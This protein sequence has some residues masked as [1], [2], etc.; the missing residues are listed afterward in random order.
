[1]ENNRELFDLMQEKRDLDDFLSVMAEEAAIIV[2]QRKPEPAESSSMNDV[3]LDPGVLDQ[4][5]P[6]QKMEEEPAEPLK[7][8]KLP[9]LEDN[10]FILELEKPEP[11][12][13]EADEAPDSKEKLPT[14]DDDEFVL[15]LEKPEPKSEETPEEQGE[16][17]QLSAAEDE[18]TA[19]EQK[20]E[21]ESAYELEEP[22]NRDELLPTHDDQ[23]PS[24]VTDTVSFN[25]PEETVAVS[26]Q[27][28]F[29]PTFDETEAAEEALPEAF[30]ESE[31]QSLDNIETLTRFDEI[32]SVDERQ[33]AKQLP[34]EEQYPPEKPGKEKK[35]KAE[36]KTG[37]Y[38][39]APESKSTPSGKWIGAGIGI[40]I[41]LLIILLAGYFWLYPDRAGKT[42]NFIKSYIMVFTTDQGVPAPS[43][44]GINLQQ[45]R[46]KQLY[47]TTLMKNVRVI[48]GMAENVT[49]RPVSRIKIA[50]NIYNAEGALLATTESYAG[51]VLIDEKLESL[52]EQWILSALKD[53]KTME[54][55]TSPKGQIPFMVVFAGEPAG[56]FRL[57]VNPIDLKQH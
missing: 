38:D 44:L 31:A 22:T 21:R 2:A 15:E 46:Q 11:K 8:G 53:V 27:T 20:P 35:K 52:N 24:G 18:F 50:A 30:V 12:P 42:I 23:I 14:L 34:D 3:G 45:V 9:T 39:F 36:R 57:T 41:I 48:E 5:E 16:T 28:S 26:E 10:E 33:P 54:D 37:V 40:L 1:M 55:R 49:G 19:H 6:P 29:R 13:A 25:L 51:N 7:T 43:A 32:M 47:N 56:I 17:D 4:E